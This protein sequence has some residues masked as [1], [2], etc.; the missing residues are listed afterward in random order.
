MII[1]DIKQECPRY[2]PN[3][4]NW[5]STFQLNTTI[6][7]ASGSAGSTV[8][9]DTTHCYIKQNGQSVKSYNDTDNTPLV[10]NMITALQATVQRTG[11]HWV[12]IPILQDQSALQYFPH[13]L[14][15]DVSQNGIP[16]DDDHKILCT[17]PTEDIDEMQMERKTWYY[18][19]GL[20]YLTAGDVINFSFTH[21]TEPTTIV[22]ESTLWIGAIGVYHND[23]GL[24]DPP[25]YQ[26]PSNIMKVTA[27]LD[28][29]STLDGDVSD[30]TV[31]FAG[32]FVDVDAVD[33]S[34]PATILAQG[35]E[36]S[37]FV[38][39]NGT[40]TVRFSNFTGGTIDPNSGDFTVSIVK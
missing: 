14:R 11:F 28:F 37:A 18:F 38:S 16:A 10:W 2:A 26:P 35:G 40:V 21:T 12:V 24:G 22:G 3:I 7:K 6:T 27:T 32:A 29:P 17:L 9:F 36:Y 33:V 34:V 13:T 39:S 1:G 23:R 8:G 30:L 15:V 31:S 5:F 25:I 20:V 4:L 19:S